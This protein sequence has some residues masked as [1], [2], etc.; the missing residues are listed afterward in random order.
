MTGFLVAFGVGTAVVTTGAAVVTTGAAVVTEAAGAAGA[1]PAVPFPAEAAVVTMLAAGVSFFG[2][3][4]VK[5]QIFSET[6]L[7]IS[8]LK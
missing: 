2:A 6:H 4:R 7:M 8:R 3:S 5:I 1:A